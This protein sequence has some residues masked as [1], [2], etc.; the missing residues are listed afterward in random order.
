MEIIL[1][2]EIVKKKKNTECFNILTANHLIKD[3]LK[4]K[5]IYHFLF[6]PNHVKMIFSKYFNRSA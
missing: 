4:N 1:P 3:N 6:F 5:I 2:R